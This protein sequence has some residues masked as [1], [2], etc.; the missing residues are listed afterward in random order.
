VSGARS[1]DPAIPTSTAWQ[2][3]RRLYVRCGFASQLSAVLRNLGAHWDGD[4]RALW[5][6]STKKAAVIEAVRA[7]EARKNAV[8]AVKGAGRWVH[9][10][11]DAHDIRARAKDVLG[12]VYGG[13]ARKGW[14]A[15]PTDEGLAEVTALVKTWHEK[16]E[17]RARE[18]RV[19]AQA[20]GD[21]AA[22]GNAQGRR[23][24]LLERSGRTPTGET[25]EL[26]EISTRR[27]NKAIAQGLA[28]TAGDLVHLADGRRGIVTG[29][30]VWFTND[31]MAS[32]V[33]WHPQTHDQA[34]WDFKY[35]VSIVEPTDVEREQDAKEAAERQDTAGLSALIDEAAD[36]TAPRCT[37]WTHIP[38]EEQAGKITVVRGV[39]RFS[40]GTLT[41]TRDGRVIWQHP[42]Y[43]DDYI[44]TE[45]STSGAE[46]V[47]RVRRL[48]TAGSR[49]RSCHTGPQ[50]VGFT[51]TVQEHPA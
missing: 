35:T 49:E 17:E 1:L 15:M 40:A 47:D 48:I 38:E 23:E 22:A 24:R 8:Q 11:Y 31:E 39:T 16:A 28:S 21:F 44:P 41:L 51:V 20:A 50:P 45:G 5:I 33:C 30:E 42:G 9:I 14:W 10:P 36:L 25:A 6:G 13:D 4:A 7:S 18:E 12:G 34:H 19:A 26:R 37:G 46:V 27:M 29:V 3:G 43:Y 32:S 2:Q